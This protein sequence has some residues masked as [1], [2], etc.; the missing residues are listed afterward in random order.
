MRWFSLLLFWVSCAVAQPYPSK[1][2]RFIVSF[3]PGGSADLISRAIAPRMSEK[4]GQP[5]VVE[6]RAG[7]GGMIGVDAVAKS[8]PDGTTIGLAAAGALT[9][10]IHIY[11]SMPFHPEKDL[12]PISMLAMIPFFLVAH[13]SQPA[14]LKEVIAQARSGNLAYGHG[15][16]GSTMHL[17]GELLNMMAQIKLQAVPYKGSG[18][19]SADVLGGQV[20]LGVV[21]VPSAIANVKAGKMRALAVTSKQRISAAPEVPT[22]QEAGLRGYEAVGWFGAVAP[23]S[24]PKDIINRLNTEIRSALAAPDVKERALTA[25]AEPHATSPEEFAAYIR[26]ET[27]KWGEVVR[28]AGIKLQ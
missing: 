18:P 17:A 2:I 8:A 7:A 14:T 13:P 22:F 27:K 19:V 11:P 26:E 3:P 23:A 6:N 15:G 9:T 10:N 12:A 25:G 16:Q 20:P 4:L 5:V 28:A 24:T 21:D 1:P